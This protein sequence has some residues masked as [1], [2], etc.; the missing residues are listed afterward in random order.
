[1]I[2]RL[3]TIN[4]KL[5]TLA[6]GSLES[7]SQGISASFEPAVFLT[8]LLEKLRTLDGQL[9]GVLLGQ[10]PSTNT[11]LP[12]PSFPLLQNPA[13]PPLD[14]AKAYSLY[15]QA[16]AVLQTEVADSST[17]EAV[18][19]LTNTLR[20]PAYPTTSLPST[21]GDLDKAAIQRLVIQTSY[22]YGVE[23]A[24]A[25][26]VAKAE[27][28]FEP[29]VVSSK[30]AMGVMQL[31]P[32]TAKALGVSNP[33][34]PA[35]N[36]DGGIRY[37][38]QLI[39]RF[40]GNITLAVA[41]YNAGPNAVRRYGGVPPYPETQNFVRRVLAYRETFL[42][43]VSTALNGSEVAGKSLGNGQPLDHLRPQVQHFNQ[44]FRF[45]PQTLMNEPATVSEPPTPEPTFLSSE[46]SKLEAESKQGG[47]GDIAARFKVSLIPSTERSQVMPEQGVIQTNLG[48]TPSASDRNQLQGRSQLQG[49]PK[50]EAI[51]S[52]VTS[53]S[54]DTS[55][56]LN[57]Q[58][59]YS[60]PQPSARPEPS[61]KPN[62]DISPSPTRLPENAQAVVHRLTVEVPIAENGE[63]IKLQVSLPAKAAEVPAVQVSV[64]VSGEQLAN[65]LAQ[66]FPTLRQHLLEQGI[67]LAQWVVTSGGWG[68]GRRDPAEYFGDWRRLPSASHNRLP[69][70][71][72][73]DE[74]I[75]A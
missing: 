30:G 71:F 34:D 50:Q 16:P 37:L 58:L 19:N 70:S 49:E 3:T 68:G 53:H 66:Q 24:L 12:I 20:L 1:M 62:S 56:P 18:V 22:R 7:F 25:L 46:T 67:V 48:E 28:D 54:S 11:D 2:E 39:E 15:S 36:I 32:E 59:P 41:A 75:W 55:Q 31:M 44:Q 52:P 5:A 21:N 29:K 45:K 13:F 47:V 9:M 14:A 60:N 65:Q 74:G 17:S 23:P 38:K 26:A 35:Q 72:I 57:G 61:T 63:H 73:P 6:S 33:F 43:E 4:S 10:L 69:T 8:E 64:K 40:G 27:S 51:Q 42:R